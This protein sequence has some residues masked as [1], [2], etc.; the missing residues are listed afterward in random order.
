VLPDGANLWAS[1]ED[2][3]IYVLSHPNGWEGLPQSSMRQAA[4]EA[5]LVTDT[6]A[7]DRIHFVTEGEASLHFCVNNGLKISVCTSWYAM[8]EWLLIDGCY[9]RKMKE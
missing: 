2:R 3:I 8:P 7:Q 4:V 5:G 9:Y 6:D 1:V